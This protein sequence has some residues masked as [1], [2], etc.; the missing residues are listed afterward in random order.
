MGHYDSFVVR[1]WTRE[2]E[3]TLRGHIQHVST[4][5]SVSFSNLDKMVDF[6][7]SHLRTPG[8]HLAEGHRV[9]KLSQDWN[10]R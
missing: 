4:Q 1:I 2:V 7:M 8:N 9:D 6:I 10:M 5:E 3:G